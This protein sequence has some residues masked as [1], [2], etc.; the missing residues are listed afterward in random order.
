MS[1]TPTR[2]RTSLITTSTLALI[3]CTATACADRPDQTMTESEADEKVQEHIEGALTA[4]P[5]AV[6]LDPLSGPAVGGCDG[7]GED[8]DVTVSHTYWLRELPSESNEKYTE[9]LLQYWPEND[10]EILRDRRP[11]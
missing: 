6:E 3:L 5:D 2:F 7:G 8:E 1:P 9:S 10:Y 4:L 11:E